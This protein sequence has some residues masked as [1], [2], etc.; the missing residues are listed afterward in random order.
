MKPLPLDIDESIDV[1]TPL[2]FNNTDTTGITNLLLID[3]IVSESQ[4]FFDSANSTTF[5]II[6]SYNSNRD[7]FIQ[8]LSDKFKKWLDRISFV[9]HDN[10]QNGKSFLNQELLFSDS[11]LEN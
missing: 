1:K 4:L 10:I 6:Y 7:D 11:M 5:P 2:V 3:S 8:L 9:F